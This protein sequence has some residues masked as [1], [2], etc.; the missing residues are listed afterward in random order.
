MYLREKH[1]GVAVR[2]DESTVRH[3]PATNFIHLSGLTVTNDPCMMLLTDVSF[4][5][6]EELTVKEIVT[7][8][9]FYAIRK[10]LEEFQVY[11]KEAALPIIPRVRIMTDSLNAVQ[12]LHAFK[13][14]K[15]RVMIKPSHAGKHITIIV[16]IPIDVIWTVVR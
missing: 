3:S 8:T 5:N 4:L 14:L 13:L 11:S 2:V 10:A 6:G 15:S 12:I 1:I 9:E 7:L 16:D